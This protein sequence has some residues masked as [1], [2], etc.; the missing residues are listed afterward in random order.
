MLMLTLM[1]MVDLPAVVC[2][3]FPMGSGGIMIR[4]LVINLTSV[5]FFKDNQ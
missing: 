1:F 2:T 3:L 4:A 5:I